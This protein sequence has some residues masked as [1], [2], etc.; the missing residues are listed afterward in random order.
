M[1]ISDLKC[2]IVWAINMSRNEE[3]LREWAKSESNLSSINMLD[4]DSKN[5]VRRTWARKRDSLRG[6]GNVR[7]HG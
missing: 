7:K 5:E 2:L 6:G 3:E 4:D 1:T